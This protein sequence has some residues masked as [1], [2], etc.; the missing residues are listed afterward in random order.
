MAL[1]EQLED[2]RERLGADIWSVEFNNK[3]EYRITL[4]QR[5]LKVDYPWDEV[6]GLV[7]SWRWDLHEL[8]VLTVEL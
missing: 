2:V 7:D 1:R 5:A 8:L 6:Y 4:P 3:I